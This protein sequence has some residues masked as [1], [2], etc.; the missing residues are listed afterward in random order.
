MLIHIVIYVTFLSTYLKIILKIILIKLLFYCV[1]LNN[2]VVRKQVTL[3][4][5]I[6]QPIHVYSL[7]EDYFSSQ[8]SLVTE[9]LK[10]YIQVRLWAGCIYELGNIYMCTY[11]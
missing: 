6:G 8:N 11:T 2:L 10:T 5:S 9:D 7:G 1:L 4:F 3:E